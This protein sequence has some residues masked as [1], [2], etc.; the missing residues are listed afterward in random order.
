MHEACVQLR[1]QGS[2]RRVSGEPEVAAVANGGDPVAGT[3][4]ATRGAS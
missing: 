3:V 4:L 1:G 2:E